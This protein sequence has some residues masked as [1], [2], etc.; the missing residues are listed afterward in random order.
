MPQRRSHVA[1]SAAQ[2]ELAAALAAL[3]AGIDAP[4]EFSAEA[5][6]E[7]ESGVAT[8]PELDLRDVPFV[9]LDP[10]GS[11]DLDQALHLER[12]GSGF[13]VRYAIADVPGFVEPG[14]AVDAEARQRGQTLYDRKSTRLNSSHVKISYAV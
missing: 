13:E 9:T 5:L 11:R 12:A 6:A 3:R 2:S 7:A 8:T 10:L 14:R 4:T 1:P